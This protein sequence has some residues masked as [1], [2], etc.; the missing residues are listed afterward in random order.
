M[1]LIM[2]HL[3]TAVFK[4]HIDAN[5]AL[6]Q[7]EQIG[8][9]DKQISIV[10]TDEARHGNF[11]LETHSKADEGVA[12]GASAG[13]LL[14]AIIGALAAA[15]TII[16]P[17]LN[18]VVTGALAGTL[19]GLVTGATAGGLVGGLIGLG[20]SEHEAKIYEKEIKNGCMLLA[21]E[22][23]DNDQ[24][25]RVKEIFEHTNATDLAA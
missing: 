24:R 3:V 16:V 9:L 21:V 17:G 15:G 23:R 22:A 14:G 19:A 13:G 2:K 25:K 18:L 1:E 20:I 7:L 8:V 4:T 6:I 11:T 10:L 5:S 12:L